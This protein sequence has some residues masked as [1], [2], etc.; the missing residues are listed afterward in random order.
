MAYNFVQDAG[1]FL[2][3]IL[4]STALLIQNFLKSFLGDNYVFGI[5]VL[6]AILSYILKQNTAI[7]GFGL[8]WWALYFILIFSTLRF[9]G[10]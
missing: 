1:S 3:S 5:V 8:I 9:L 10:V 4:S 6:A 2:Y 7:K